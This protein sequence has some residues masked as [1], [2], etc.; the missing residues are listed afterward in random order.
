M[1]VIDMLHLDWAL[2]EN[3]S[4]SAP[5]SLLSAIESCLPKV[6]HWDSLY[7]ITERG[8]NINAS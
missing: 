7:L 3:T 4:G 1:V 8:R 5:S 2:Q 6:T